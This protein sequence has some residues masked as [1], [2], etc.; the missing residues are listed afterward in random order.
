ML[1]NIGESPFE[2]AKKIIC[3]EGMKLVDVST[4]SNVS[5]LA[6]FYAIYYIFSI[7]YPVDYRDFFY[8]IDTAIVGLQNTLGQ[9]RISVQT[10]LKE[11][12]KYN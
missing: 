8:F 9:S 10:F 5:I 4:C 2:S 3:V 7:Q 11:L 12:E 1:I 6:C